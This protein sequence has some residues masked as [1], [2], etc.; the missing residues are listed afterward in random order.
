MTTDRTL[1]TLQRIAATLNLPANSFLE[2][3][4]AQ[5]ADHRLERLQQTADL[6][7]AFAQITDMAVRQACIDFVRARRTPPTP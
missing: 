3:G 1:I 6:I 7:E 4:P 2:A 5:A